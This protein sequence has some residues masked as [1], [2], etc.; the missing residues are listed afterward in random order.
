MKLS[1]RG[2]LGRRVRHT[3]RAGKHLRYKSKSKKFSGSAKKGG[4]CGYSSISH[5]RLRKSKSGSKKRY[6][7]RVRYGGSP[8]DI[9]EI[10]YDSIY[11]PPFKVKVSE[12]L[13]VAENIAD[14]DGV[15]PGLKEKAFPILRD[16]LNKEAYLSAESS[17]NNIFLPQYIRSKRLFVN[18]DNK[19]EALKELFTPSDQLKPTTTA[20][21]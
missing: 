18:P 12:M 8:E 19:L 17:F 15:T 21:E 16:N 10:K 14:M 4:A 11:K 13:R 9:I 6:T 2:K 3:K 7:Q 1:R 5:R 20:S